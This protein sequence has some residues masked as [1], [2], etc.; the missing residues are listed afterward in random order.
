MEMV[1]NAINWFEIPVNDFARAKTF[2]SAIFDY[3]MPEMSM[4]GATLGILPFDQEAGGIG[5]AIIKGEG[6]EPTGN[7]I[8]VYLNGGDDLSVVLDR[9]EGAGGKIILPK[10]HIGEDS[11]YFAMFHDTEGNRLALHS[12][13]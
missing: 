6:M 10:T 3:E 8:M 1:T 7:G 11:G 9:V 13:G 12:M 5:G 4:E 2:Y